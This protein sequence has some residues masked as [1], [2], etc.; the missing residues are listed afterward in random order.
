MTK[1][2]VCSIA[3]ATSLV[4][5]GLS[6]VALVGPIWLAVNYGAAWLLTYAGSVVVFMLVHMACKSM[7]DWLEDHGY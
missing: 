5:L 7:E 2:V 4:L 3:A 6:L 1:W